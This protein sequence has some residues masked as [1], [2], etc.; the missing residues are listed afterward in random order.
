M[1]EDKLWKTSEN[2][3]Q[4]M[5]FEDVGIQG[6]IRNENGFNGKKV[7]KRF[8]DDMTVKPLSRQ[9]ILNMVKCIR[10]KI[11]Q[12]PE[13]K[14]ILIKSGETPIIEDVTYRPD[15]SGMFWGAAHINQHWLGHN[16]LGVIWMYLRNDFRGEQSTY[17]N[18]DEE[19]LNYIYSRFIYTDK[20]PTAVCI[21]YKRSTEDDIW[22]DFYFEEGKEYFV[23]KAD[24]LY[25]IEDEFGKTHVMYSE[26]VLHEDDVF[27][28]Y[29]K[30]K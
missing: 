9:D 19:L 23:E 13:I 16:V 7:A 25:Y 21:K 14:D 26:L 12:H 4:A 20:E 3:F 2:L 17:G 5:R 18:D 11:E 22:I 6:L 27:N 8:A 24:D 29:F 28:N 30:M 10:L 15:G 1:Y